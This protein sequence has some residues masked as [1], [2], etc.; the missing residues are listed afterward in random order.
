MMKLFLKNA[1]VYLDGELKKKNILI[2]GKKIVKISESS[3]Q[4]GQHIDCEGKWVLP[5]AID[6]HVH[7][8]CPGMEHKEDWHSGSKAAAAGGVTTVLDMPNTNPPTTTMDF[9]NEKRNIARSASIINFGFHF[10]VS[11]DNLEHIKSIQNVASLKV[12][13]GSSTGNLLVNNPAYLINIFKNTN[14]PIL[15]HAENEELIN[16]NKQS[17]KQHSPAHTKI[18]NIIRDEEVARSAVEEIIALSEPYP[19][20]IYFCHVS[21]QSELNLILEAKK[22][23]RIYCEVTPHHLF[24]NESIFD[25]IANFAKVNPPLRNETNRNFIYQSLLSDQ[26]DTIATDH[27]PHL[28]EE[29]EKD[30][31]QAPAGM[32]GIETIMPLMLT[33]VHHKQLTISQ[34]IKYTAE[35]SSSIFSIKNKGKIAIDY[36]A[37]IIIV[38]P[39]K[40][41]EISSEKL[42]SKAK[43]SPFEGKTVVGEIEKTIVLGQLVYDMGQFYSAQG[44][45]INYA[46]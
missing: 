20:P 15:F 24:L 1:Y 3:I 41:Y 5:G 46:H 31:F 28:K 27:A 45:E 40:K 9:L 2:A 17:L 4:Q 30:Y 13:Y 39:E 7:F 43:W 32:P 6:P 23:R 36:D 8:R 29:K 22:N 33:E 44:E 18:H 26:I 25:E 34:L 12:Y 42:Y 16:K 10:G 11:N 37:D 38:N 19:I 21:C 35:S 14:L